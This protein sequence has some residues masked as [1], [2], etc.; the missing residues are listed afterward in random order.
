MTRFNRYGLLLM[1]A[2]LLAIYVLSNSGQFHIVDEVSLFAVTESAA[3]RGDVDTNA[4]AWTQWVNSPGE[5]LGSFGINGEVFSKKGPAPALLAVPWYWLLHLIAKADIE[6]GQLQTVLLWN[7]FVTAHT[8][9]LLAL[10]AR[11]LGYRPRTGVLLGLLFGLGTIAWPYAKQFFGE[12]LSAFSLLLAFYGLASWRHTGRWHWLFLAGLGG[13]L[14]VATVN[15]HAVL[16]GLLALWGAG[17]YL[18]RRRQKRASAQLSTR[19][20]LLSA[21]AFLLPLAIFALLLLL[22]NNA[23]FGNPFETGYHFDSGEGFTTPLWQGLW[24]QLLSPYR[25]VFW[26]TPLFLVAIPAAFLFWRRHRSESIAIFA[27]S[28]ALLLLYSAWWMWWGGFAWGPRFLVPLAPFWVL[29]LA[30]VAASL[31][32]D[33]K[34]LTVPVWLEWLLVAVGLFSVFVQLSA[35][36]V[37]YV[38]FEIALRSLYP[39]DWN[40]PLAYGPPAQSLADLVNSPVVGQ[41]KLMLENFTANTDLAWLWADGQVLWL[42]AVVGALVV[43]TLAGAL[44]LWWRTGEQGESAPPASPPMVVLAFLLPMLLIGAW[45]GEVSRQ[46]LYGEPGKA[47]RSAL[48]AICANAGPSDVFV[49]VAPNSYHIPMNW[50]P[51]EC[52]LQPPTFGFAANSMDHAEAQASLSAQLANA[53]RVWLV[54]GGYQPNDP[55]NGVERW[56]A[57]AAYKATDTWH[58]DYR[59]LQYATGVRINDV[60]STPVVKALFGNRAEQVTV[61]SVRAPSV[62]PAGRPIPIEIT[63]RV[64][65]PTSENLRWFVQL[66]DG[67]NTPFAQL[68]T[69]PEDNYGLFS[70]LPVREELVEKAGLLIPNNMPPGDYQLIIGLYN[71]DDNA[72]R[73]ENVGGEDFIRAGAVRVVS[74]D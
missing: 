8:A 10:T 62:A 13:G 57:G 68:D 6:F 41:W 55:E 16:I 29:L 12:P 42:V 3:L 46:P 20:L 24:G 14:A 61:V 74:I 60:E 45:A 17:D 21:L 26:H 64:E 63:Y 22:Y 51:G 7:S 33:T 2:L 52:A 69:G 48:S 59:V 43:V 32:G 38:N 31:A 37:N 56:L 44:A 58:D 71:P 50:M 19:D 36:A 5:V 27:I 15:A 9:L 34:A 40:D 30:P 53:D 28:G 35:V 47:Y 54:T 1:T 25:G 66:W 39:T 73:L 49:N 23:R 67:Q 65:A 72:A 11:R 18:W 4:I 70:Q